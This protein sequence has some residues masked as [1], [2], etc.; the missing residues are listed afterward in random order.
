MA[1][2]MFKLLLHLLS[3]VK[4]RDVHGFVNQCQPF[5]KMFLTQ[6]SYGIGM[7]SSLP[8]ED[9]IESTE[10]NEFDRRRVEFILP[11]ELPLDW[12]EERS[13]SRYKSGDDLIEL[14]HEVA[15][16]RQELRDA[17]MHLASLNS[18]QSMDKMI[19]KKRT[20]VVEDCISTACSMDPEFCYVLK[21]KVA[22]AAERRGDM[23]AASTAYLEAKEARK[24]IPQLNMHGLWIGK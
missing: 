5:S 4:W 15:D 19:A 14:R 3:I 13:Q 7:F 8:E 17:K 24:C 2:T 6:K 20:E 16:L 11:D 1:N 21:S 12:K 18:Y 22:A 10:F 9:S 23:E